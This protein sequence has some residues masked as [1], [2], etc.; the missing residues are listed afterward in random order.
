MVAVA[1]QTLCMGEDS[2]PA[3]F[4]EAVPQPA[5]GG[6]T[7]RAL[8]DLLARAVDVDLDGVVADLFAPIRTGAHDELVALTQPTGALQLAPPR[9]GRVRCLEFDHLTPSMV[10]TQ[11]AWSYTNRPC[12]MGALV[13]PTAHRGR[14]PDFSSCGRLG[15]WPCSHQRHESSRFDALLDAVHRPSGMSTEHGRATCRIRRR[16]RT[17][18]PCRR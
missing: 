8:L 9:A 7:D 13:A 15:A 1:G 16:L 10:A 6:D 2:S 5:H 17:S 18:R 14:A 11:P 4:R 3:A 12:L